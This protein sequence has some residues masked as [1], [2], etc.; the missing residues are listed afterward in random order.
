M[1]LQEALDA[2]SGNQAIREILAGP[3]VDIFEIMKRDELARYRSEVQ[4][5]ETREVTE[6]EIKEYF[7]DF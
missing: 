6:W 4:D 5:P 3:V 1:S 7:L 2:L